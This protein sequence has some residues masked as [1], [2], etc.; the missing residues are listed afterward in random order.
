MG[1]EPDGQFVSPEHEATLYLE[2]A[3]AIHEVDPTLA[4]GGPSFQSGIVYT[5]FDVD[6][7][8]TWSRDFSA[9]SATMAAWTITASSP[10]NGIRSTT[11]ANHR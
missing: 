3:T 8:R 1:E 7:D 5:G 11:F 10:S 6:P 2:F 4:L 9:I